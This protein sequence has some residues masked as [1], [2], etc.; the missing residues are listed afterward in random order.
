[1]AWLS[2]H[3]HLAYLLKHF[4]L[5]LDI[6]WSVPTLPLRLAI[7]TCAGGGRRS[8]EQFFGFRQCHV[9]IRD[10]LVVP[11]DFGCPA[12]RAMSVARRR[13]SSARSR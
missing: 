4:A 5:E 10:Q 11:A 8:G 6:C 12:M 2:D 9:V 3:F 1:M 7:A 13:H